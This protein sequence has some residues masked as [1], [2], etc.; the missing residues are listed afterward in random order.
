MKDTESVIYS[1][2]AGQDEHLERFGCG[3]PYQIYEAFATRLNCR[4]EDLTD[5]QKTE[6]IVKAVAVKS[7]NPQA[8]ADIKPVLKGIFERLGR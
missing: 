2:L 5:V 1:I 8:P 4:V 6:A 7:V 3:R